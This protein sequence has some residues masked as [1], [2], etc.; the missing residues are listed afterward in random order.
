[1][2]ALGDK[3]IELRTMCDFERLKDDKVQATT[4]LGSL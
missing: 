2:E 1:M 4:D 3:I